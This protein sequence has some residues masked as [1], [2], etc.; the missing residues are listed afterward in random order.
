MWNKGEAVSTL[1][2]WNPFANDVPWVTITS[3]PLF[4]DASV[5]NNRQTYS[6][7]DFS[8]ALLAAIEK[9]KVDTE[10]I[11]A[12]IIIENYAGLVSAFANISSL[13]FFKSRGGVNF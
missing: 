4:Y 11:H 6:V 8:Q 10:V 7:D 5:D 3:H 13:G 1:V 2:K 12:P 9:Q